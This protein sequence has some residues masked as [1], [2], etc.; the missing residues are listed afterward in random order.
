VES[1]GNI[2]P[3]RDILSIKLFGNLNNSI[4]MV[5]HKNIGMGIKSATHGA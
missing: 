2:K 4:Y 5:F 3:F 1:Q